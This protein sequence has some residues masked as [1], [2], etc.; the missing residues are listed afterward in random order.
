[1]SKLRCI[2]YKFAQLNVVLPIA[3]VRKTYF[4]FYRSF[5]QYG[6]LVWGGVKDNNLKQNQNCIIKIILNKKSQGGSTNLNY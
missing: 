6:L 4:T 3:T 5:I 2:L 1:V